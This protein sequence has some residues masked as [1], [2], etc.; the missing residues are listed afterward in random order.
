MADVPCKEC[1]VFAMCKSLIG[2]SRY[3]DVSTLAQNK[4]C[5]LLIDYLDFDCNRGYNS[6]VINKARALFGL[7]PVSWH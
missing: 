2:T 5:S 7:S 3:Y 6:I 4:G 1:I